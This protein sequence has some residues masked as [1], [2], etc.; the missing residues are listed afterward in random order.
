MKYLLAPDKFKGSL[1]AAEVAR[2]MQAGLLGADPTATID[3]CPVADG[4]EG[5][6]DALVAA[7][8]GRVHTARV[9]GPLPETKVDARFG[10]LGDGQTAVIEMSAASGL[11]LLRPEDR[12]PMYTTTF[13]TGELLMAAAKLSVQRIVLGI[14]GSATIDA[15]IGCAQACGLPVILKDGE[16]LSPTEPLVGQDLPR[17]VLIKHGRGSPIEKIKLE[18][19]SDVSNPLCGPTGAARV[20]GP[21]K[22]ATPDQIDFLDAALHELARRNNK[23][24]EA[25]MPGAGAAGGLG[26]AMAAFFGATLRSGI[27]LV[28]D[29]VQFTNRLAGVDLCLTGEGRLDSQSLHGKAAA[30]V[31]AACKAAGVRCV[32]IVGSAEPAIDFPS[33]GITAVHAISDGLSPIPSPEESLE[34]IKKAAGKI[35]R[36]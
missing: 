6:V 3:L 32:A 17:V 4:G 20:Y 2:A 15:G 31:A 18:V 29:A 23:L 1:S 33:I 24:A 7:T 35:P 13:G 9:T 11:A 30:G 34:R 14:G 22:G 25:N 12:N 36:P 16:P 28:L 19:A 8:T 10:I 21:Q 5:T 26:F 27:D